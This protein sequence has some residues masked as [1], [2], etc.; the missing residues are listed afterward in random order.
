[1]LFSKTLQDWI[2]PH[3]E[4]LRLYESLYKYALQHPSTPIY[5]DKKLSTFPELGI[6]TTYLQVA[7]SV[8]SKRGKPS[9]HWESNLVIKLLYLN[10]QILIAIFSLI[11]FLTL[12]QLLL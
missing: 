4:P 11:P 12:G 8:A 1:M 7:Q 5:F 10:Q 2:T 3:P 9:S 6:K